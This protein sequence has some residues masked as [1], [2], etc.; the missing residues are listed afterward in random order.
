MN[1]VKRVLGV[2]NSS[3]EGREWLVGD[4][5]TIAD[6]SFV[7]YHSILHLFLECSPDDAFNDFPDVGA[8]YLRVTSRDSWKKV[9]E[10]KATLEVNV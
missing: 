10:L 6:M 4:K 9:M 7:P 1:E 5:M 2:L 8:W 3:L